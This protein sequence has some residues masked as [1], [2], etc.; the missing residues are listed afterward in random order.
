MM[1]HWSCIKRWNIFFHCGGFALFNVPIFTETHKWVKIYFTIILKERLARRTLCQCACS[2]AEGGKNEARH[3]LW[4]TAGWEMC[5]VWCVLQG[6]TPV[7]YK[8]M[9]MFYCLLVSSYSAWVICKLFWAFSA[10]YSWS[11]LQIF[12]CSA[13][14]PYDFLLTKPAEFKI[15]WHRWREIFCQISSFTQELEWDQWHSFKSRHETYVDFVSEF[16]NLSETSK[17]WWNVWHFQKYSS[18]KKCKMKKQTTT[19]VLS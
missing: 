12:H 15:L 18:Y 10:L 16:I 6:D 5:T 19:A 2:A 7:N 1:H 17:N 14:A 11:S 8:T 13:R 3:L 9:V 4:W